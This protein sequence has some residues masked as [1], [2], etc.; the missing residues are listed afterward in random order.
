MKKLTIL[1]IVLLGFNNIYAQWY[2]ETINFESPSSM[3]WIDDTQE[4]NI[5]QIGTPQKDYFDQAYSPPY[6][7]LSDT[8]ESYGENLHSSFI[9][10]VKG[11]SWFGG[12]PSILTFKH[13]FDTDTLTDGGYIDV[14][15]DSG[16]SWVSIIH[17]TT[18]YNCNW[19]PGFGYYSEN[20]YYYN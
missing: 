10:S 11:W 3:V 15:Y 19:T 18:M 17:D 2:N 14:S 1:L 6:A 16:E 4:N 5:W 12:S 20:F 13:K 9:V 8:I 7:I